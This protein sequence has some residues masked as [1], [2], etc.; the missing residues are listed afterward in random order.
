MA[1]ASLLSVI[2]K[3]II[4]AVALSALVTL[5]FTPLGGPGRER[6]RGG[7]GR[8]GRGGRGGKRIGYFENQLLQTFTACCY[9]MHTVLVLTIF[10][11]PH[12]SHTTLTC[13]DHARPAGPSHVIAIH[14]SYCTCIAATTDNHN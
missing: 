5:M 7:R 13:A 8:R 10:I 14:L 9:A 6:E 1:G 4:T 12:Y 3:L 2:L 11:P